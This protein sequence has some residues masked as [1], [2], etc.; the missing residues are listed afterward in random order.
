MPE[1]NNETQKNTTSFLDKLY[2]ILENEPNDVI[3]WCKNGDSFIITDPELFSQTIMG[4]YFKTSKFNSFV[5]QLNFYG[6]RKVSRDSPSDDKTT[7]KSW[8]FKHPH[9]MKGRKDLLVKI[10]RKQVGENDPELDAKFESL[11]NEILSL[12]R[13]IAELQQWK[14]CIIVLRSIR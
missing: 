5:R 8:E 11:N 9:F 4:K 3:S 10:H 1:Q 12:K 13:Q 14:V 7:S 6:F 2:N